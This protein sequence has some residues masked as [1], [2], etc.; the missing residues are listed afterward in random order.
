MSLRRADEAPCIR[1]EPDDDEDDEDNDDDDDSNDGN[2]SYDDI[3]EYY[4]KV[5]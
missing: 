3:T 5:I 4:L 1:K 2:S